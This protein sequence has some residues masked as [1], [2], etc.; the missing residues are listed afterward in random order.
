MVEFNLGTL[1]NTQ[2]KS[3]SVGNRD[4][5][6]TFSFTLG[7]ASDVNLALTG[8][9]RDADVS[10]YRDI[11]S[12]G[13]IDSSVD[14]LIGKST[15]DGD[16]DESLNR[17]SL[18]AGNYLVEVSRFEKGSTRYDLSL[19][20]NDPSNLL[21]TEIEVDSLTGNSTFDGFVGSRDT[22]DVYH[23]ALDTASNVTLSLTGKSAD[24]DIRLIQDRNGNS[25]VDAGEQIARS[26]DVGAGDD[27][28]RNFL[29]AD[30]NYF[31]QVFQY[32]GNTNY[33]LDLTA[34]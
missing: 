29:G 19:S 12:D 30:D 5:S 4:T 10:L 13:L 23:F 21:P 32:S 20:T 7:G 16:L 14:R 31:V 8:M 26:F 3:N 6:D 17:N 22:V 9:S 1:N 34:V 25:V 24:A 11:N 15:L 33:T 28:L 27:T 18:A 2:T